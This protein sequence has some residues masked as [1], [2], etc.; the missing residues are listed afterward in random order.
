MIGLQWVIKFLGVVSTIILARLLLPSDY[1]IVA[2]ASLVV[3]FLQTIT[4]T[5]MVTYLIRKNDILKSDYDTAWTLNIIIYLV[6][7]LILFFLA[8]AFA[9]FF[10]NPQLVDVFKVLSLSIALSG[11]KNIGLVALRKELNYRNIFI[12][13]VIVKL[14]GFA[15]TVY[16][17]FV[18]KNYWAM[19]FGTVT[20]S[21]AGVLFS[22]IVSD[23]KPRFTLSGFLTQWNYSKW[24]FVQN[25]SGFAR[26]K[27]DQILVSKLMGAEEIGQ[28]S[29]AVELADLPISEI[30]YPAMNPVYAGYAKL[31]HE[32]EKLNNAFVTFFGVVSVVA[33][34]MLMGLAVIS[35]EF[36]FLM[37][38]EK[39]LGIIS[40]FQAALLLVMTR[41]YNAV[42][43]DYLTVNGKIKLLT[44]IDWV[45]VTLLIP[46]LIYLMINYNLFYAILG[47]SFLAFFFI[48]VF[49]MCIKKNNKLG[50]LRILNVF[51]R[52]LVAS[53][54]MGAGCYYI[55]PYL[56]AE[57][58]IILLTKILI[59]AF[60]YCSF[61]LLIWYI[62][63]RREGGEKFLCENLKEYWH[64]RT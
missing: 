57:K 9:D 54:L 37:L 61:L 56:L 4:E 11:F 26:M 51:F 35:Q 60:L 52:P 2:M 47:R 42:L 27:T 40:I 53:F 43:M 13:S 15:V 29:M 25:F 31:L 6:I 64:S 8:N 7:S 36:I 20:C 18:L 30:I 17:A 45:T 24:Y 62:T 63:G 39:W 41:M 22:Y 38:G 59:G 10:N 28:Y 1:G 46:T 23:Y 16:L 50:I 14:S 19:V 21:V 33:L 34:P 5:G 55:S 49:L 32:P 12:H 58:W 44:I 3:T 48:F